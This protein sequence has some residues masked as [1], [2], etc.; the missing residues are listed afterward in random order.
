MRKLHTV[1][2]NGCTNWHSRQQC[3]RVPFSTHPYQ[4]LFF[5]MFFILSIMIG[6]RCYVIVVL[7]CISLV[8]SDVKHLFMCLLPICVPSLHKSLFI[9]SANF[10]IGLFVLWVLSCISSLCILGINPLLVSFY[11]LFKRVS[12][13]IFYIS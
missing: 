13:N 6:V 1:L 11:I 9:P 2:H 8:V 10:L 4:H 3:K 7:I 5:L 12:H